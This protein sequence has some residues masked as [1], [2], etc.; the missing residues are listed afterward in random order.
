MLFLWIVR[1]VA[2][3]L[4]FLGLASDFLGIGQ[5]GFGERQAVLTLAGLVLLASSFLRRRGGEG[6]RSTYTTVAV[7][8]LNTVLG[9]VLLN[10]LIAVGFALTD[11]A[12][13]TKKPELGIDSPLRRLSLIRLAQSVGG[14]MWKRTLPTLALDDRELA[15]IYPGWPRQRV[16]ELL[17][18]S[19]QRPL[20][21]NPYTQFQEKP[22]RG[23]FVNVVEP[24]YRLG[25][26]PG[27]WP[28]AQGVHNVW[29]FGGSTTFGY[30]LPDGETIP[31]LLQASLRRRFPGAPIRVY[32][33]GQGYFYSAQELALLQSLLAAGSAPPQVAVFID[34][35]N[36]HQ[37]EP[38]YS[39]HLRKLIQSPV[40]AMLSGPE[41][42]SFG[43][44][45]DTVARWLRHKRAI[46]GICASFGIKPLFVW[47]PAP[48]WRYDL[49][50][51]PLWWERGEKPPA[52]PV[53][54]ESVHYAAMEAMMARSPEGLG[55]NFLWLGDLQK[56]ERRPLYVDRLHYTAAFAKEIAER[57]AGRVQQ[58]L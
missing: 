24:G 11:S 16:E 45:E 9:F 56:D 20:R 47:Q 17:A 2:G 40:Q 32:N 6:G 49:R 50:H 10:L 34:G 38:Y 42:S 15:R 27:P 54:G 5:P 48:D 43:N 31:S 7:V 41:G 13:I 33:F 21:F 53:F 3:A 35:I 4:L 23:R 22:F 39:D 30:G 26:D 44:G 36:E 57:I 14:G 37:R 19:R 29:V 1:L 12:G 25:R 55:R 8:L 51:H 18:E 46:E 58:G 52:G 28:M